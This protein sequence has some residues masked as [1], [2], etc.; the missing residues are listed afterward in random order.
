MWASIEQDEE[1]RAAQK[2]QEEED[3]KK[4]KAERDE[5]VIEVRRASTMLNIPDVS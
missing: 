4:K 3:D 2:A 5:A 1:W